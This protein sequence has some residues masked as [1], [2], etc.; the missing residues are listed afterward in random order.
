[1][2]LPIESSAEVLRWYRELLPKALHPQTLVRAYV[3]FMMEEGE[4]RVRSTYGD[5]DDRLFE[6]LGDHVHSATTSSPQ[7][8]KNT[9]SKTLR[10][11]LVAG[12]GA[13]ASCQ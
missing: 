12:F 4:A 6:G 2:L 9:P 11:C 10:I 8:Q 7:A 3:N 1:M 5:N 13:P